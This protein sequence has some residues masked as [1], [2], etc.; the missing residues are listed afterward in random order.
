MTLW[1]LYAVKKHL[2]DRKITNYNEDDIFEAYEQLSKIENEVKNKHS[3]HQ[4][5]TSNQKI[6]TLKSNEIKKES[7]NLS[8]EHFDSLFK[9]IQIYDIT[10]KDA[11]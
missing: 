2:K 1:D 7:T 4:R 9:D 10:S 6:T 5:D 11:K 8:S 3:Q